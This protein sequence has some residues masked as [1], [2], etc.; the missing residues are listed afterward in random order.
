MIKS[1]KNTLGSCSPFGLRHSGYNVNTSSNSN[2]I[3]QKFKF[4]GKE[5]NDE[6]GLEWYDFGARNYDAALGRWMNLDPLAEE[7]RRHS[8]YNYAFNNP[9]FFVDPD[10]M[11][12][13]DWY[14]NSEGDI[15]Y[16]ENINS[17]EDLDN[18]GIEGEYIDDSFVGID[19]NQSV[20]KFNED[21]TISNSSQD[22]IE[23]GDTVVAVES[24]KGDLTID[25]TESKTGEF[26]AQT[27][28]ALAVSQED[29]PAPGP[30]D[31]LAGMMLLK[32][33][34]NLF[35]PV[36]EQ[37]Y[38]NVEFAADS[39]KNE[40]HGDAGALGKAGQRIADLEAQ[41]GSAKTKKE[42]Q[43]IKTKIRRERQN[44]QKKRK[45]EEHSRGKKQ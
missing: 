14:K 4:G 44:A 41:L 8:P 10:G 18:A 5:F 13:E 22:E 32:A 28:V 40:K 3:A 19:E 33:V 24:T 43:R 6:L 25:L 38:Y 45:G 23:E 37:G 34:V 7:M 35:T 9:I 21:G 31:V 20:T 42:R 30:A 1:P 39:S 12:P 29:S 27:W 11:A 17:Q 26:I 15:V 36:E 2:S 16:D